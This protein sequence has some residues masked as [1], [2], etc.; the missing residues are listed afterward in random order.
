MLNTPALTRR[1]ERVFNKDQANVLAKSITEAYSDLVKTG[2]FNELKGLVRDLAVAQNRTEAKVEKLITAQQ[3]T[4]TRV[5]EL[6]V[7]QQQTETRL[8][9]LASAQQRTE[10]KLGELASAQQRTETKLGELASAQQRTEARVDKL[11]VAQQELTVAQ[12]QTE[13]RLGELASAQQRTETRVE[14]LAV[15]MSKMAQAMSGMKSELGG[16]SR[17][18]SYALENEAFRVL[19]AYLQKEFGIVVESRF[20]RTVIDDEELDFYAQGERDGRPVCIIGESKLRIDDRRS[21]GQEFDR[22][23][24]QLNRK[25]A[26]VK[27]AYP[28]CGVVRMLV[29]HYV[30]PSARKLLAEDGVIVVQSFDWG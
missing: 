25:A 22:I 26:V 10:T 12:Q 16:L 19:P 4:E 23:M 21:G 11:T 3:R 20:V 30:R 15:N 7:A 2:D 27:K 29:T 18:M 17:T 9:E 8:G 5:E 14:E 13:T 1:F 28:D 6:T 24:N